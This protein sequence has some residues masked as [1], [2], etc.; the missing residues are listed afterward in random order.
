MAEEEQPIFRGGPVGRA[1]QRWEAC[2]IFGEGR[3]GAWPRKG[4]T[5][6]RNSLFQGR[7]GRG[8]GGGGIHGAFSGR[9]GQRR[10]GGRYGGQTEGGGGGVI[11][12]LFVF[13]SCMAPQINLGCLET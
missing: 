11:A 13:R 3:E 8:R 7:A 10:G 12:L 4:F 2:Y 5:L 9:A 1:W 6:L